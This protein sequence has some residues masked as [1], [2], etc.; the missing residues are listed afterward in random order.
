MLDK[1]YHISH[2]D[3]ISGNL[4]FPYD[5]LTKKGSIFYG[6]AHR[7][8]IDISQRM[9]KKTITGEIM[10]PEEILNYMPDEMKESMNALVDERLK[11]L[12]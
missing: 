7:I 2:R 10:K 12:R 3:S 1:L 9:R 8:E 11:I 6:T 5:F 4:F